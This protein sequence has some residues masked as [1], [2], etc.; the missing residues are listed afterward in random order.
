[1]KI[2]ASSALASPLGTSSFGST[3][4]VQNN[5]AVPLGSPVYLYGGGGATF[6]EQL[7]EPARAAR[8]VSEGIKILAGEHFTVLNVNGIDSSLYFV[9]CNGGNVCDVRILLS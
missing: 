7:S 3:L 8:V 5:N 4:I 9:A 2:N 1:M 6:D